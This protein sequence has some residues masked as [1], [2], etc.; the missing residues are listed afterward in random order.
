MDAVHE[1]AAVV[2]ALDHGRIDAVDDR[3][4]GIMDGDAGLDR[5]AHKQVAAA[6]KLLCGAPDLLRD[7]V[8]PSRRGIERAVCQLVP[9]GMGAEVPVFDHLAAPCDGQPGVG[10]TRPRGTVPELGERAAVPAR[11]R[12]GHPEGLILDGAQEVVGKAHAPQFGGRLVV[13]VLHDVQLPV[14]LLIA[15]KV[16]RH[17]V[18]ADGRLGIL[19]QHLRLLVDV[20]HD[21]PA[22]E[23]RP[24]RLQRGMLPP[25]AHGRDD[26]VKGLVRQRPARH[27]PLLVEVFRRAVLLLQVGAETRPALFAIAALVIGED[28]V[29]DL[30]ADDGGMGAERLAELFGDDAVLLAHDGRGLAGVAAGEDLRLLLVAVDDACLGILFKQPPR[31]RAAGRAHDD[32]NPC[33]IQLVYDRLEPVERKDALL[34]LHIAPRKLTHAHDVDARL[35][36]ADDVR[37]HFGRLPY[38]GIVRRAD[39]D[40]LHIMLLMLFCPTA[41][42]LRYYKRRHTVC[43]D[44]MQKK[45]AR[46][47]RKAAGAPDFLCSPVPVILSAALGFQR[48]NTR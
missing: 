13:V 28:L 21:I 19:M 14:G 9:V 39:I 31:R 41:V 3:R 26:L 11:L 7:A 44:R 43:Q 23:A 18:G 25:A 32:V 2:E 12:L 24:L 38:L 30:P 5:A 45:F 4:R 15:Q 1:R 48:Y 34:R 37:V 16:G 8:C 6:R 46:P 36:H 33:S 27:A 40:L 20:G 42:S 17:H 10:V 47:R 22:M 35:L 29:V